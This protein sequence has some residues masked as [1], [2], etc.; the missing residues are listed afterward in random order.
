MEDE[1]L[2]E[3]IISIIVVLI[4]SLLLIFYTVSRL[5]LP[6]KAQDLTQIIPAPTLALLPGQTK[7]TKYIA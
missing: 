3:I 5:K 6:F 7:I 1:K 4:I 2:G